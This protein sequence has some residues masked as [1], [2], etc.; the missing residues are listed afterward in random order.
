[1]KSMIKYWEKSLNKLSGNFTTNEYM[2]KKIKNK[3]LKENT[4]LSKDLTFKKINFP[5]LKN[6]AGKI[7]G[8]NILSELQ[9]INKKGCLTL[10]RAIRFPTI[11]RIHK[12]VYDLG[13]TISNYEQERILDLYRSKNYISKRKEIRNDE[14]FWVQPQER[15]VKGLPFFYL[16]NDALQIHRAFRNKIDRVMII[17]IHIP[18]NLI[19]KEKVRFYAN[20][21]ID[22]NYKNNQDVELKDFVKKKGCYFLDTPSLN[23]KGIN[24]YEIYMKKL[25]FNMKR[26]NEL[27]I[28]QKFFLLDIC[29][30]NINEGKIKKLRND[31]KTL[32]KYNS[33]LYG[34][35]GDY[36]LFGRRPS[37][38]LPYSCHEIKKI[39]KK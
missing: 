3:L 9:S 16:V 28:S 35:F 10:F 22:E 34:F 11:Y 30:I 4:S 18:F 7:K 13:F 36:N 38:F 37:E 32:E 39:A 25:S 8:L 20:L 6:S 15:V 24:V 19:K 33:F 29:K 21:D 27:G 17:V 31:L 5:K 1:M 26:N 14:N 23:L 12:S 2:P